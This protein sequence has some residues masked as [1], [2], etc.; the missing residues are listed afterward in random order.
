[1]SLIRFGV[2]IPEALSQRFDQL[3]RR[4]KYHNRSEAIRNLIREALIE[5]EIDENS[6]VVGV[7]NILYDHHHRELNERLT[8]I[9]HEQHHMVLSAMHVHLDHDNCVEVIIV[10]GQSGRVRELAEALI[11]SKGVKHG[12]LNLTS[13]GENIA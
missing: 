10:K 9:Q 4:K 3:I 7:V 11:A 8:E 13:T 1:M 6:D 5:E 2:S 12:A